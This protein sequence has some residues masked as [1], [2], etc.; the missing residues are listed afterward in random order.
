MLISSAFAQEVSSAAA[1]A[2]GAAGPA[3]GF[4]SVL[5]LLLIF[6]VFYFLLIRPQQKRIKQHQEVIAAIKRGDKVLTGGGIIGTV[7]KVEGDDTLL[8]E[9]A[10]GVVVKISR[11]TVA[12]VV[13]HGGAMPAAVEEKPAKPAVKAAK[14]GAAKTANDN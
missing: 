10:Q 9:I 1:G 3:S 5:P 6:V 12:N 7:T 11:P 13:V 2:A 14:A 8:V 4:A